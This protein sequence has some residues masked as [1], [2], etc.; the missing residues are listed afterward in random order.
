MAFKVSETDNTVTASPP[1]HCL[2]VLYLLLFIITAG[3]ICIN[4]DSLGITV[5]T[6]RTEG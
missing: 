2:I 1:S 3:H 4:N 5:Q 6:Q